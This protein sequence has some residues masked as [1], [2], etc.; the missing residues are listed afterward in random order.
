MN[1]SCRTFLL[2]TLLACTYSH[3][4]N[5]PGLRE[6]QLA[7]ETRDQVTRLLQEVEQTSGEIASPTKTEE[8]RSLLLE[9]A[10]K[11]IEHLKAS[12]D[13]GFPPAQFLYAQ[14]FKEQAATAEDGIR[15]KKK[16][17]KLLDRAAQRG[18]LAASVG[19]ASYCGFF[20]GDFSAMIKA[21]NEAH[22]QLAATLKQADAYAPYYPLKAFVFPSC[23]EPA[24]PAGETNALKEMSPLQRAQTLALPLLT[25]E[26]TQAQANFLLALHGQLTK[27]GVAEQYKYITQAENLGCSSALFVATQNSLRETQT[28]SE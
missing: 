9:Y 21:V 28:K 27:N 25:L 7:I 1:K 20:N 26:E 11:Y 8:M 17:C 12:S 2:T 18:L 24:V 10:P 6:Y 14:T 22:D 13:L 16:A 4:T 23:F 3:A 5:E 19:K 15:N